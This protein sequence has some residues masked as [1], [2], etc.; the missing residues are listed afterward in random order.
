MQ[1]D[2]ACAV[3]VN[4]ADAVSKGLLA[5]HAGKTYYFSSADCKTKFEA[6]PEKYIRK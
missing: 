6:D 1:L 5:Q 2:V 3:V 4:R